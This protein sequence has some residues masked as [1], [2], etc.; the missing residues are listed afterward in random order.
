MDDPWL[1]HRQ[2]TQTAHSPLDASA[3][4]S[5]PSTSQTTA[6]RVIR[7]ITASGFPP[8]LINEGQVVLSGFVLEVQCANRVK[9]RWVGQPEVNLPPYRRTFLSV[10]ASI[11]LK[12]GLT[13]QYVAGDEESHLICRA[14]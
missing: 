5:E 6:D 8:L 14:L 10:Y 3:R 13:I 2:D 7:A 9:V 12:A 1:H 4:G 11:L